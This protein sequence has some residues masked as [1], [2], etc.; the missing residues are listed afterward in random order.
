MPLDLP[1]PPEPTPRPLAKVRQGTTQQVLHFQKYRIHVHGDLS[2]D[3]DQLARA[4]SQA[5]SLSNAV[6]R[7]ALAYRAQGHPVPAVHY[8]L[9]GNDLFVHVSA[10][11]VTSSAVA[12]PLAPYFAD[13][14][15]DRPLR[16]AD[17]E[18]ARAL[19]SLHADRAGLSAQGQFADNGDG[20]TFGITNLDQ[21]ED[22][23]SIGF[24]LGNPGNRFVG[25]HFAELDVNYG[26]EDGE[27]LRVFWRQAVADLNEDGQLAEDYAEQHF[28]YSHVTPA[29][30][31][32][33]GA[34][35]VRF[36]QVIADTEF[37]ASLFQGEL[38]WTQILMADFKQRLSTQL[39]IDRTLKETELSAD[40]TD[41]QREPYDSAEALA[42]YSRG[43]HWLGQ[44]RFDT[45]L[46]LI[47]RHGINEF[48]SPR[49]AADLDYLLYRP[50]LRLGTQ[51]SGA[52]DV[53]WQSSA[54]ITD[55]R[56]PEQ[57]QWVLGGMGNLHAWLPGVAVGDSGWLS[58]IEVTRQAWASG[59]WRIAPKAF[60]EAGISQR[61]KPQTGQSSERSELA[62]A[63]LSFHLHYQDWA[64]LQLAV[65][66]PLSERGVDP[67]VLDQTEADF[68][69]RLSLRY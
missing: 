2:P 69:F 59:D 52:W 31:F 63:G 50:S 44:R 45:E 5:D 8:A 13:L 66:R 43:G 32:G 33:A 29:G 17:F 4:V 7:L 26:T 35:Y 53:R 30:I 14:P 49:T 47:V 54:Q 18:P 20:Y 25:R 68:F 65:A 36:D 28:A 56:V 42:G 38:Y 58:R 64:E 34:K 60:V 51:L 6:R 9:N 55:N 40:G 22:R 19:A 67:A 24:A 10:G 41:L 3:I 15:S 61:E 48:S 1:P 16:A 21:A 23:A 39:K 57:Q 46:G 27:E 11:T 62:D 37:D 12:E